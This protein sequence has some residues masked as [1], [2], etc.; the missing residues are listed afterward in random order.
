[1]PARYRTEELPG[2]REWTMEA[3]FTRKDDSK[4][5]RLRGYLAQK[6]ETLLLEGEAEEKKSRK[7]PAQQMRYTVECLAPGSV[8]YQRIE[9]IDVTELELGA[10][11]SC[12]AEWS[13]SPYLGGKSNV[14]FG[15]CEAKWD[16]IIPGEDEE[17]KPFASI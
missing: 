2:W 12:L 14:G 1:L 4:D 6:P 11:V 5:E 9:L 17:W 13:K 8:M 10:W 7:E 15:L 16:Y 3:S